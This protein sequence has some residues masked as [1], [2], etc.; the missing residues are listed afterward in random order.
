M[1][2][3]L[4]TPYL[5]SWRWLLTAGIGALTLLLALAGFIR[6]V[7]ALLR[8]PQSYDFAA[9]YVAA[10]ALDLGLPLY[11]TTSMDTAALIN[12]TKVPYPEYIYPPLLAELLRPLGAL[13]FDTA[14]TIWFAGNLAALVVSLELLRRLGRLPAWF[15]PAASVGA[16]MLPPVYSSLLLGQINFVLL[17][18]ITGALYL[19][20]ARAPTPARDVLSGL[21]LG[22]AAVIKVYPGVLALSFVLRRRWYALAG[23]AL[24][25]GLA[26]A[27]EL[28]I[29][30]HLGNTMFFFTQVLPSLSSGISQFPVNTSIWPTMLR[31]FTTNEFNFAYQTTTNYVTITTRP[32]INAPTLGY[33]LAAL[34]ALLVAGGT[35]W[36]LLRAPQRDVRQQL[37]FDFALLICTCLLVF[38][39]IHD[40]YYTLAI[41]PAVYVLAQSVH[42][43]NIATRLPVGFLA[44]LA[45][46]CIMLQRYWGVLLVRVASPL[47]LVFGLLGG[48]LLW[49][50]VLRQ[51][52][53]A[54]GGPASMW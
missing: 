27:A 45:G 32:L 2:S 41:V 49:I 3:R 28:L 18:L 39:L 12:G 13:P 46:L 11:Q 26:L 7:P 8:I 17:L 21:L 37:W 25:V 22:L 20:A 48:L 23:V 52:T 51:G 31:L 33:A 19:A 34:A 14:R 5:R 24:G 4:L 36:A 10:R 9:Y 47:A 6:I 29:S 15:T 35:G 16:L 54:P 50:M 44:A 38:P 1:N 43:A 42:S 53:D 30:Q 40:H